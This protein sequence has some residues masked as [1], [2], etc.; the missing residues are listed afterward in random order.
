M[1]ID[2]RGLL[3]ALRVWCKG[4]EFELRI[5]GIGEVGLNELV[6]SFVAF[7]LDLEF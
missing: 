4:W 5:E 3:L 7:F 6:M 2:E 1:Q